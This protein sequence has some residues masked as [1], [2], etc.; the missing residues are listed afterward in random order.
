MLP[1]RRQLGNDKVKRIPPSRF[2]L[3]HRAA[4][5]DAAY[6][7][8]VPKKQSQIPGAS[9]AADHHGYLSGASEDAAVWR[10]I[11]DNFAE[12]CRHA[13]AGFRP[14]FAPGPGLSWSCDFVGG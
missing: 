3:V 6:Q 14:V 11:T 4:V 8:G 13:V 9:A 1:N 7:V 2:A 12:G 5:P 10:I